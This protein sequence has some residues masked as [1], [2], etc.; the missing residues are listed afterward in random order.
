MKIA[1]VYIILITAVLS[2]PLSAQYY[3]TGQDPA[4]LKW[5]QIKTDHFNL[6]FPSTYGSKGP[7]FARYLDMA[8]ADF[9]TVFPQKKFRIPV[10]IHNYTTQSN[11]YVA[12][13]P[14]RMELYPTPEQNSIP[15][16]PHR[17]L[18]LHEL[19][20]VMQME[21]LN[22]G[23]TKGFSL[24]LGEQLPGAVSS[25]LPLWFLEGQAVFVESV[26]SESGRGRSAGFQ[27]QV[28]AI[29][30]E[31]GNMYSY[32]KTFSGSFKDFVP[33]HYRTGYQMVAWTQYKYDHQVWD[34]VLN[35]TANAPF[36]LNPVNLSLLQNIKLTK[37]GLFD[38]TFDTLAKTWTEETKNKNIPAYEMLNPSKGNDYINYYSPVKVYD[39]SIAAVKTSL[40]NP[41]EIVIISLDT[42]KE[43]KL[44]VPGFLYPYFISGSNGVLVWVETKTDPRWTNRNY[45]VIKIMDL[46]DRMIRQLSWKSRYL[47]AAVSPDGNTIAATEN[48]VDD[49]NNLVLLNASTGDIT[50]TI[51]VPGNAYLQRPQWSPD[52]KIIIFITLAEKGEGLLTYSIPDQKWEQIVEEHAV[53]YQSAFTRNDSIFYISSPSGTENIYLLTPDNEIRQITNSG[54]GATDLFPDGNR[55]YFSDYSSQGNNLCVTTI[56]EVIQE[57]PHAAGEDFFII[58]SI[59]APLTELLTVPGTKYVA[60][61]YRKW[62]HLFNFHSWMP[63]YADLESVKN[64]PRSIRPGLTILSQ[65]HLSTLITSLGY[66]YSGQ[67]HKFH[68]RLTWNGWYPVFESSIDYGDYPS[69]NKMNTEVDDPVVVSPALSYKNTVSLPLRFYTGKFSQ[70]VYPSISGTYLSN[71][72]Y[73]RDISAYDHG[74]TQLS[75]RFY[76]SN[77]FVSAL[78]DIYPRWAQ[79]IDLNFIFF[80]FDKQFYGSEISVRTSFYFPGIL[81]NNVLRIRYE[82]EFQNTRKFILGNQVNYP[83]SYKNITSEELSLFSVDYIAPLLYP[84]LNLISLVYLKRI[85]GSFFYDY[86]R[87]TNN[88]YRELINT[89]NYYHG[90]TETFSSYG[91]ELLADF[92]LFR[93]P[94]MVSAGVQAAWQKDINTPFF[95]FLLNINVFGMNIGRQRL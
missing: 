25:L 17:Q 16:D 28:K 66:E 91:A 47:S 57:Q 19:T 41:P 43:E 90:Y 51:P 8:Y 21:S 55:I 46:K 22:K 45:S 14:K 69:I 76:F 67:L 37:K 87:G 93:L 89:R 53:D 30:V 83:R 81:S 15:L 34:K 56:N 20:H 88:Y 84:D 59:K 4:N 42:R 95:E 86:G 71:Y 27:K 75:G 36:V 18:T 33:D 1:S 40:K 54:F 62:Q 92:Y 58:N 49:M 74:Q 7:E 35:L 64:D 48:S 73:D 85:R 79:I 23:F 60:T 2:L 26:L 12:W 94:Y 10:I 50:R 24:F 39:N 3:E 32:D 77:Y 13:A 6:I 38:Q 11:G 68:S 31:K 44:Q 72:I 29:A 9:E 80:P 78:R 61:R 70:F 65:N 52:G 5:M 82:N 63:F